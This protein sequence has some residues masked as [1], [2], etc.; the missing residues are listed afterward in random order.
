MSKLAVI[1]STKKDFK[2]ETTLKGFAFFSIETF[3]WIA[4]FF[5]LSFDY[6][7]ENWNH[8]P[9]YLTKGQIISKRPLVTSDSPKKRTNK[10]GFFCLT[11]L[12]TNL[13]V[14]FLEE[15]ENTKK[16]FRNYLTFNKKKILFVCF[17]GPQNCTTPEECVPVITYLGI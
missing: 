16:S 12:K 2:T 1:C 15:S 3:F 6:H 8:I 4:L 5:K 11:V 9:N 13:F 10:F 7:L 14:R 17:D